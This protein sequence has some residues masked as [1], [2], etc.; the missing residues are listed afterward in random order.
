VWLR[1][2][3]E[4]RERERERARGGAGGGSSKDG[5]GRNNHVNKAAF[6]GKIRQKEA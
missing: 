5:V 1:V 2:C 3:V 6:K 4:K